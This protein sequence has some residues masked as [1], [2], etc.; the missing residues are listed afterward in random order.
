MSRIALTCTP[1]EFLAANFPAAP[2]TFRPA[3]ALAAAADDVGATE[4]AEAALRCAIKA[5]RYAHQLRAVASFAAWRGYPLAAEAA[6]LAELA[7]CVEGERALAIAVAAESLGYKAVAIK[8]NE[9][10]DRRAMIGRTR[11]LARHNVARLRASK[12]AD[13][14]ATIRWADLPRLI[15]AAIAEAGLPRP[16]AAVAQAA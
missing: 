2:R 3:M 5:A 8:A 13:R 15:E 14:P 1:A 9:R 6:F 10:A 4:V 16:T 7:R 12:A 11:A